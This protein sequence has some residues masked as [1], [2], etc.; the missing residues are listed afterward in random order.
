MSTLNSQDLLVFLTLTVVAAAVTAR[1]SQKLTAV[2]RALVWVAFIAH[3]TAVVA[4]VL[5]TELYF[6]GGDAL[7]YMLL[8]SQIGDLIRH[9]PETFVPLALQLFFQVGDPVFPFALYGVGHSTGSMHALGAF[10]G[11]ISGDG[12]YSSSLIISLGTFAASFALYKSLRAYFPA[13]SHPQLAV[14]LLL[15][16]TTVF[17]NSGV[18]KEPIAV[19]GLAVSLVGFERLT[20]G[21]LGSS[22]PWLVS[23]LTLVGLFK[24]YIL[25]PTAVGFGLW[26]F[27]RRTLAHSTATPIKPLYFFAGGLLTLGLLVVLGKLFPKFALDRVAES[28]A[29]Q[30]RIG[31]EVRGG[32]SYSLGDATDRSLAGQLAFAPLALLTA[33]FRPLP[34]EARNAASFINAMETMTL[35]FLATRAIVTNSWAWA[36][37][38]IMTNPVLVFCLSFVLVM[39]TAVGLS[40]TNFGTLS[41]YRAPLV[42]FLAIL[43]LT[44]SAQVAEQAR[45][46]RLAMLQ[47]ASP[48][49][50]Q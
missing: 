10:L 30:Q 32:S 4:H 31:L 2:E 43:V 11:L 23:G 49:S 5:M 45:L 29:D 41:R 7:G 40:T 16:P 18:L 38:T 13:A 12:I 9:D 37:R 21:R 8:G 14:A 27:T 17:W 33:L 25:F 6:G 34:F 15:I 3:P 42:P 20:R 47:G 24:P 50:L 44:L 22:V 26:Y 1:A 35:T 19:L 39:A 36:W 46:R 28:A 48:R